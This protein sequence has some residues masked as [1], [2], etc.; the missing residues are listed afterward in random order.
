MIPAIPF[1]LA[2]GLTLPASGAE[3]AACPMP[4]EREVAAEA[5]S[6]P[7]AAAG[8][9][10]AIL[11]ILLRERLNCDAR[12]A[13][14]LAAEAA[15]GDA[16]SLTALDCRAEGTGAAVRYRVAAGTAPGAVERL[17]SDL[18]AGRL[19][20]DR[21]AL[22]SDLIPALGERCG[23]ELDALRA[24]SRLEDA[25]VV[26]S[27]LP[28][29]RALA[30]APAASPEEQENARLAKEAMRLLTAPAE[31]A[32]QSLFML[33]A[34]KSFM[35]SGRAYDECGVRD[36]Q[37]MI[38]AKVNPLLDALQQQVEIQVAQNPGLA[39]ALRAAEADPSTESPGLA[40]GLAAMWEASSLY[41][42]LLNPLRS[43]ADRLVAGVYRGS[44]AEQGVQWSNEQ[45]ADACA[46]IQQRLGA[47]AE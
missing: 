3:A 30:E 16:G 46:F 23:P 29:I 9:E 43:L 13:C 32:G 38:D 24:A 5:L 14:T 45:V 40:E 47:G 20:E 4:S 34:L 7:G 36:A 6:R 35:E 22:P 19:G 18:S 44:A 11:A 15:A 27:D 39:D 31:G 37:G 33:K 1:L 2:A 21:L 10:D 42:R 12:M 8:A 26:A 41:N 17:C 28:R 25:G